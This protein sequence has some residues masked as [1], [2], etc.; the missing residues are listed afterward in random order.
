MQLHQYLAL[1]QAIRVL[2]IANVLATQ[3]LQPLQ[4]QIV[5]IAHKSHAPM[6]LKVDVVTRVCVLPMEWRLIA[7]YLRLLDQRR[8]LLHSHVVQ[9]F[10][11][12]YQMVIHALVTIATAI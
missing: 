5:T 7:S 4:L 8:H 12:A 10:L 1:H 9:M 6:A 3:S 2:V 11:G